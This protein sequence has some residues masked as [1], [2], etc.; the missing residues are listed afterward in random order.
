MKKY[1]LYHRSHKLFKDIEA[2]SAQEACEKA[3]WLIGDCWVRELTPIV[4]DPLPQ[5]QD[6]E[7]VAGGI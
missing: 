1:R 6:I 5:N 4:S 3:G 2:E 7:V